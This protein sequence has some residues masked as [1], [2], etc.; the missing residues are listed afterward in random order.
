MTVADG[1][2]LPV[3]HVDL[4]ALAPGRWHALA[5]ALASD[6][7]AEAVRAPVLVA[8]GGADG[9]TLVI[10]AALHGDEVN[11][12]AA[13]HRLV[14]ELPAERVARGAI[15]AV[16]VANVPGFLAHRRL[17]DERTDLNHVMP[18]A[19][20]GDEAE[21]YAHRLFDRLILGAAYLCDLHTASRGRRNALY[22]RADLLNPACARMAHLAGAQILLH[23][24]PTATTLRG[25]AAA[26]GIAAITVEIGDPL[27]WEADH[28]RAVAHGLERIAVDA[29][30]V[31]GGSAELAAPA[32]PVVCARSLWL[33][34]PE[35][36]LLRVLPDLA[37]RVS[38]GQTVARLVDVY[39]R[40]VARYRSP[41]AGIVIGRSTNPVGPSGARILHL[42]LPATDADRLDSG[43]TP[44]A[45]LA[46]PAG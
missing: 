17:F 44:L 40:E 29:G 16:L 18:G 11:G 24:P 30:I 6:A 13:I 19:P 38:A 23:H 33:H 34:A 8:R 25:A 14:A 1:D 42:G 15:V 36:G 10:A 7:R 2:A 37:D 32:P 4:G 22:V 26:A 43:R 9:P 31:E 21:Q 3:A 20:D 12:V 39:G 46:L 35:G 45:A 5:V 41:D 27:V 28:A